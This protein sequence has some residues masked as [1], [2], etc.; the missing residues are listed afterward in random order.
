MTN[1]WACQAKPFTCDA[2]SEES[3]L[4]AFKDIKEAFPDHRITNA[5]FNPGSA[6]IVK[7]FFELK[8]N[9]IQ[10]GNDLNVYGAF[11]FSQQVIPLLLE[12]GGGSLL[13]TG[14][15]AAIRG[16][17]RFAAY[18]PSKFALRSLSQALARE[19]GPQGIH[20]A[21]TI[22]DGLID[23]ERVKGFA[24]D[25]FKEGKVRWVAS[26]HGYGKGTSRWAA[27]PPP[28]LVRPPDLANADF[29][30][31][32]SASAPSPS[33][34]PMYTSPDKTKAVGLK[35]CTVLRCAD[36]LRFGAE[37]RATTSKC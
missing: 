2:A 5:I 35:V 14:A 23:T 31:T 7:P 17:A 27:F 32:H 24:G 4:Q 33:P 16:S 29:C 36:S 15:T 12:A 25:D 10:L 6:F 26:W 37:L 8:R 22:V 28:Q 21:H 20:V 13:F 9:D 3:I 11:T 19:F 18:S 34:S 1:L 30:R